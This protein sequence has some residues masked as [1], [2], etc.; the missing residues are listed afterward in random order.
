[1]ARKIAILGGTGA[2]GS[3]L[4]YRWAKAGEH[5]L[6]LRCDHGA[7]GIGQILGRHGHHQDPDRAVDRNRQPEIEKI[8]ASPMTM[9]GERL[10]CEDERVEAPPPSRLDAAAN[11]LPGDRR[12]NRHNDQSGRDR[13][14]GGVPQYQW[15][16]RVLEIAR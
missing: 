14:D 10:R 7:D 12:R 3:G 8:K 6:I 9:L 4:A 2:E 13:H 1:M 5:V 11:H 16:I 15:R